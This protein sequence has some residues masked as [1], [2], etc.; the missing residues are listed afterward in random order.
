VRADR[1]LISTTLGAVRSL[2]A[3]AGWNGQVFD[4]LAAARQLYVD[5]ARLS[6]DEATTRDDLVAAKLHGRLSAI[7]PERLVAVRDGYRSV[8][9]AHRETRSKHEALVMAAP[10]NGCHRVPDLQARILS[11]SRCLEMTAWRPHLR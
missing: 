5:G 7:F 3:V 9:D 8:A 10:F 4:D 2:D 1:Q 6:G 11:L